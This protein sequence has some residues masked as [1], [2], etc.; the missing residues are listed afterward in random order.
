MEANLLLCFQASLKASAPFK[1]ALVD[2]N[3]L[4]RKLS[5]KRSRKY[6]SVRGS[7][8]GSS[9]ARQFASTEAFK[10]VFTAAFVEMNCPHR[11]FRG[12]KFASTQASVKVKAFVESNLL[13]RKLSRKLSRRKLLRK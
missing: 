11:G 6:L 2:S 9:R 4:S 13:S 5:W 8:H 7:F 3:L 1:E 12:S 10:E